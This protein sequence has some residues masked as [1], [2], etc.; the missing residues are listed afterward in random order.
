MCC[1]SLRVFVWQLFVGESAEGVCRKEV[2]RTGWEG[3]CSAGFCEGCESV[4][5]DMVPQRP[6]YQQL[7]SGSSLGKLL[8]GR[9]ISMSNSISRVWI[10]PCMGSHRFFLFVLVKN[11]GRDCEL[12]P[13]KLYI[14]MML[15]LPG[16]AAQVPVWRMQIVGIFDS[17]L[18]LIITALLVL[19]LPFCCA[20]RAFIHSLLLH[21][22]CVMGRQLL[23][24]FPLK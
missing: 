15:I 5:L 6:R 13:A 2:G 20:Q 8:E 4:L 10:T 19:H 23:R 9:V 24:G 14:L 12:W 21:C 1:L 3:M 16:I 18:Q 7:E 17:T 22:H 11:K